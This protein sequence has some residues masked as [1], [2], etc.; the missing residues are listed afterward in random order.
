MSST[1][2]ISQF[3]G[4][5]ENAVGTT[6]SNLSTGDLRRRFNFSEKVY[7]L[8]PDTTVLFTLLARLRKE[9]VDDTS[10]KFTEE[11]ETWHKRYAYVI[12]HATTTTYSV[13]D[14]TL[15]AANVAQGKTYYFKMATDYKHDG[16]IPNIY[17]QATGA[18]SIGAAG[19]IPKFFL[20]GDL[21]KIPTGTAFNAPTDY[22]IARVESATPIATTH[23]DLKT[24]IIKAPAATA[25]ELQYSSAT[26]PLTSTYTQWIANDV[27]S[28][29]S[30]RT[31]IV[32]SAF[33]AG[34]GYP[35]NWVDNPYS[36]QEG[37][38]QIFKKTLGMDNSTRATVFKYS[39]NEWTRLWAKKLMEHKS[40]IEKAIHF[41]YLAEI[42][43]I[44]YTEGVIT[45]ILNY[46]QRF[47]LDFSTKTCDDFLE[48]MSQFMDP[49]LGSANST[50]F[51]CQKAT[52][53]WL[54]KKSGYSA[55]N[56]EI[57]SNY[58]M[59]FTYA[60]KRSLGGLSMTVIDTPYGNI[61]CIWDSNLDGTPVK[62]AAINLNHVKYRPLIGN[63][64]N[65]DTAI[66]VG[67]QTLEKNGVDS[68]VDL[69]LT[70]AGV[71]IE[72][73]EMHAVWV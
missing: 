69:I 44:R 29:E 42:E 52:L 16:V 53:N 46:S 14:A 4:L 41:S 61:N 7:K 31:Y 56:V 48:D 66:Y 25:L 70:E 24:T 65:R 23:V 35:E 18:F 26:A 72:M 55:N 20:P 30:K 39:P 60:G 58:R 11:R 27:T 34:S 10:F 1:H 43:G 12:G 21:V 36:T 51:F 71:Q 15:V 2:D 47:A 13:N 3:T 37:K 33:A 62:I 8:T 49:R 19:T 73:A 54:H 67:V 57:S 64:H 68:R 32:G 9:S 50:V 45:Y 63:G 38:T 59:D 17:G 28:L 5:T 6:G 40:D 22:I